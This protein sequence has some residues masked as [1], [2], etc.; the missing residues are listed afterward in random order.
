MQNKKRVLIVDDISANIRFLMNMLKDKY[1]ISAAT[2]GTKALDIINKQ[3]KPDIILLDILMPDIDGYEV[4]RKLK[5]NIDTVNIPIIYISSLENENEFKVK[6]DDF[7][8]K[9]FSKEL[10]FEK[11]ERHLNRKNIQDNL[12]NGEEMIE[13]TK[14]NILV[15][16][17]SPENIQVMVE[18]LKEEYI[19]SVATS[20]Q[21]ALDMLDDF[22]PDLIL[23][24]VI[25]PQMD[26]YEL[27]KILKQDFRLKNIPVIFVTILENEQDIVKGFELGAVDY[28]IKPIEPVV[29]KARINTHLRLK[30]FQDKLIND[31]KQ[32]DELLLNQSKLAV[33]GEM[34]ENITHQWKQPLSS[35]SVATT[36]IKLEKEHNILTDDRLISFIDTIDLSVNH[37]IQTIDDFKNFL[38]TDTKKHRFNIKDIIEKTIKLL[39]IK[40]KSDNVVINRDLKDIEIVNYQNDLI[41]V[42]MNILSNAYEAL[43]QIST[44]KEISIGLVKDDKNICIEIKDNAGGIDEKYLNKIFNK[45]FSTKKDKEG[46][47]VGLYMCKNIVEDRLDGQIKAENI[48]NGACFKI[49]LPL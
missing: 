22:S 47:G 25:M 8:C 34:F 10:V 5:N 46:S 43:S 19:V 14:K 7:I 38:V 27:C 4:C 24:D 23:L 30:S 20:G 2:S 13:D 36:G 9:P 15:V 3:I 21:K 18:V 45:Y 33:L 32:K 41:Q 35:I 39:L 1:I 44:N 31:L 11:L 40:F 17:D 37:L 29:L 16:D 49:Y 42:L 28:V 6:A 26:G 48:Q 12:N